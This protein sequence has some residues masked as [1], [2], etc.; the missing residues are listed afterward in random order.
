MNTRVCIFF[1]FFIAGVFT[2][3]TEIFVPDVEKFDELLVVDGLITDAPGPYTIKLSTSSRPKQSSAFTPNTGCKVVIEDNLGNKTTLS[4]HSPGVYQTDS[5]AMR[6]VIGRSYKLTISTPSG[7]EYASTPETIIKG[8]EIKSVYGEL[9]RKNNPDRFDGYQFYVDAETPQEKDNYL[10]WRAVCTYK[11]QLDYQIY[12]VYN[13][14]LRLIKDTDTLRNCYKTVT[15]PNLYL[16]N[17]NEQASAEI[18]RLPLNYEGNLTKAL[19]IRYSL[20]VSQLRINKEAYTYWAE[21]KKMQDAGGELY[22]QQPYQVRNNMINLSE[23][24]KPVLGYFMAA[25]VSEKRI[26]LNR[27]PI[28]FHSDT[29]LPYEIKKNCDVQCVYNYIQQRPKLWPVFLGRLGANAPLY[30]APECVD[31]RKNGF[32]ARPSFWID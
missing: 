28:I 15:I 17:T 1:M 13:N 30:V 5:S 23:P 2:S 32:L 18:K 25:G 14:G 16:Y 12:G 27:P 3:C 19:T 8:L 4:E 31:C 10:L 29:C 22:T 11:F 21:I 9:V 7:E 24:E 20:N 6:G 26:F